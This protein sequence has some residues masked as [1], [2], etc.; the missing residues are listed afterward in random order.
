MVKGV[1][2]SLRPLPR[3]SDVRPVAELDVTAGE[4]GELG[5]TQPRLD[6]QG[7]Q[8]V[9][10]PAGPGSAIR[11]TEKRVDLDVVEKRDDGSLAS[12]VRDGEDPL[13]QR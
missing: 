4:P 1:Q 7:E 3:A 2:R 12:L 9:I 8:G 10:P 5:D 11:G 13:D 6:R